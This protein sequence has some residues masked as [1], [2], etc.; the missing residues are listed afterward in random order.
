MAKYASILTIVAIFFG[1]Q[2]CLTAI[3]IR[4]YIKLAQLS[5]IPYTWS[6]VNE[7]GVVAFFTDVVLRW[8]YRE[9]L[10]QGKGW[11][12][13]ARFMIK[14]WQY[15]DH[16]RAT[17]EYG[18]TFLIVTP[19]GL[20]CHTSDPDVVSNVLGHRK[21]FVKSTDKMGEASH[22]L[23]PSDFRHIINVSGLFM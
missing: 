18:D 6:P 23:S 16:R 22:L 11:P 7:L 17:L 4:K 13:W 20:V 14:D 8:Y 15:E 3:R 10:Q 12:R 5:G 9:Y 1:T 19:T 2:L 21:A